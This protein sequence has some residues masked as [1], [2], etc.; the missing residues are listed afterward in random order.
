LSFVAWLCTLGP[1]AVADPDLPIRMAEK[2]LA[3]HRADVQQYGL[4]TLGAALYRA[5]RIDEAIGRLNE[6][7]KAFGGSGLPQ[8]WAFLAM[9]HHKKGDSKEA[10]RWLSKLRSYRPDLTFGMKPEV[11]EI[12][13]LHR[14]AEAVIAGR[15]PDPARR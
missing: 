10:L 12:Q 11:A 1:D 14:E 8:D 6:S 2:A 9:A 5:G 15:S 13:I 7:E 4:G 3:D